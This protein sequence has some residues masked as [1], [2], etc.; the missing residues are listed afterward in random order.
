M[1][2]VV[3][4]TESD[5]NRLVK[6]IVNEEEDFDYEDSVDLKDSISQVNSDFDK[7]YEK[8]KDIIHKYH[9][10]KN[11][12]SELKTRNDPHF[13]LGVAKNRG[14]K[15]I[16]AKVKW[17]LPYNG[18][19]K[20]YISVYIGGEKR[21]PLLLDTPNIFEIAKNKIK[22]MVDKHEPFQYNSPEV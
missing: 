1:K 5:L 6:K 9:Y 21:Y 16:T 15:G 7:L 18:V 17:K 8:Y 20:D 11:K 3:R 2:K 4:L 10:V 12:V 14:A 19:Y 13:T 22:N